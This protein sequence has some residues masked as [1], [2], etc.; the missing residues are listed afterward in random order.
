[1]TPDDTLIKKIAERAS[2][3]AI[4]YGNVFPW[5]VAIMDITACHEGGCKLK[6][7]ELLASSDADFVHDV[8]G[9]NRHLNRETHTLED[10]FLPR[11]ADMKKG[12]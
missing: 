2:E 3:L 1:M 4:K 10:G 6:L 11:F 12:E 8:W 5:S 9:I 7:D